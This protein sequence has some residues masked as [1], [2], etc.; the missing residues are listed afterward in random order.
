M[1]IGAVESGLG[2][3][4]VFEKEEVMRQRGDD[5]FRNAKVCE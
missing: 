4:C 1:G 2:L 3:G 5:D